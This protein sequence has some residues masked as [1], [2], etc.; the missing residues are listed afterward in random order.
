MA[1][2]IYL[3]HH[4]RLTIGRNIH[5]Q[6]TRKHMTLAK[7]SR[8]TGVPEALLDHYELGKNQMELETLLRIACALDVPLQRVVASHSMAV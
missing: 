4:L 5:H 8:L 3:L 2:S 1:Y 7:L 6:R